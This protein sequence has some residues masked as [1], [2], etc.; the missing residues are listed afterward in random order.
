VQVRLSGRYAGLPSNLVE[1][2][3][4][5]QRQRDG[6]LFG[7]SVLAADRLYGKGHHHQAAADPEQDLETDDQRDP[8]MQLGRE[9]ED[10]QDGLRSGMTREHAGAAAIE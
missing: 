7:D 9:L 6:G 1:R 8:F 3:Q 4:A 2:R 5:G 10:F